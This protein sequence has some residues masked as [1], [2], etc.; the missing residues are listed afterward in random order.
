MEAINPDRRG[1]LTTER[2]STHKRIMPAT[3]LAV[4][5]AGLLPAPGTTAR[6]ARPAPRTRTISVPE[7]LADT[8]PLPAR[9]ST[10]RLSF[11]ATHIA[12]SWKGDEGTGIRYR[13]VG[14][15]GAGPWRKAPESDDMHTEKQHVSAVIQVSRALSVRYRPVTPR[16]KNIREI[17][18]DYLNTLD[19]P[20]T[21][22]T[23]PIVA[24][25]G[26]DT[27][28]I[29]TRAE[30]GADES[31][32][33]TSGGCK[34]NFYPVQQL[35]VHHTAG[36]NN[37]GNPAA[38][39][40][41]IYWFHVVRQ[42]WCDIGYNFVISWDGRVYEGRWARR[43]QPWEVHNS[44]NLSGRAVAGAHV[45]GFNSGSVGISL[46]GNFQTAG[47]PEAMRSALV[48]LLAWE[49]D[50][51]NLPPRGTHI[52]RN[53][54]TG[55]TR[56][57]PYIAGHRD[58]GQ[59]SCPGGNVYR[60]LSG[61][62]RATARRIGVGKPATETALRAEPA[63]VDYGQQATVTGT[64]KDENGTPLSG[65]SVTIYRRPGRSRWQMVGS[66]VTG[67]DGSFSFTFV[68]ERHSTLR[69]V[70]FDAPDAWGSQSPNV[71]VRVRHTVTLQATGGTPDAAGKVVYPMGTQSVPLQGSGAPV[72]PGATIKVQV[73]RIESDGTLTKLVL[74]DATLASDGTFEYLFPVPGQTATTSY[75][76]VARYPGDTRHVWGR[77]PPIDF[78][79]TS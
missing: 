70:F 56:R 51:H 18:L 30:W 72:Q 78:I 37:D 69:A 5:L 40:R 55:T 28:S 48:R 60:K 39:M 20:R 76:A 24:R 17:K 53:P 50:R 15:E 11:A 21:E 63:R 64:L 13:V 34:R 68:A 22:R 74:A 4:L 66:P 9:R 1:P 6:P 77:S 31:L 27:P 43:Y 65:R 79:V 38:T 3:L 52:Y 7:T 26:A 29:I 33:R 75:R 16:D 23:I 8:R 47:L 59:T 14:S 32:K 36:K 73:N 46:M 42:G 19:G 71:R 35:F 62:R 58:A 57:L 49:A 67:V 25:A 2:G 45:A 12:F 44:E 10:A 61:I 41:A 54:D